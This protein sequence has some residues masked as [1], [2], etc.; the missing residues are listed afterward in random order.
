MRID[1][2]LVQAQVA[3]RSQAHKLIKQKQVL[4]NDQV[5]KAFKQQ[6]DENNDVVQVAGKVI[7]YQ[8]YYCYLLNKPQG[9]ITATKDAQHRTVID[10]LA[11]DDY[12]ADIVPVGRLDKD[13]TGLLLLT[14]DG[15]LNHN[16]MSPANHV[17]K[18]YEALV[19]GPVDQTTSDQFAQGLILRDG[20]QTQP[21]HLTIIHADPKQQASLVRVVIKEGKYHQVKRMFAATG[22]RVV[23]LKRVRLGSLQLDETALPQGQYR[24][25]TPAELAQLKQNN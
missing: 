19:A 24:A 16:L 22:G 7:H 13:T 21:A 25:L 1:K 17:E 9:V 2:F 4:V 14:N 10:L 15:Q 8:E 18:E 5:V 11:K 6:I 20:L 23:E 3:T 12:R